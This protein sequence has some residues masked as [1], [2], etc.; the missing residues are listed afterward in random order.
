MTHTHLRLYLRS[1][2]EPLTW[3]KLPPRLKGLFAGPRGS[4]D[5]TEF[6]LADPKTSRGQFVV[7]QILGEKLHR[8]FADAI[9]IQ[10]TD[11]AILIRW[12]S[13]TSA[14][15]VAILVSSIERVGLRTTGAR[16]NGKTRGGKTP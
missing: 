9:A 5:L 2:S 3:D 6:F 11:L 7:T 13:R 1:Q 14:E 15:N 8:L 12:R 10:T 16:P 4:V